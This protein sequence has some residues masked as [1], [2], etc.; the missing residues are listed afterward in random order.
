MA[1]G[2]AI[3]VTMGHSEVGDDCSGASPLTGTHRGLML[4]RGNAQAG[5]GP[6]PIL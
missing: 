2:I 6:F 4:P 5:A 3:G 1:K